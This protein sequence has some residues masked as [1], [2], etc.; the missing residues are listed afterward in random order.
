MLRLYRSIALLL[1]LLLLSGCEDVWAQRRS[2]N[3]SSGRSGSFNSSSVYKFSKYATHFDGVASASGE[4]VEC[5]DTAVLDGATKASFSFWIKQEVLWQARFIWAK[6]LTGQFQFAF[7][8]RTTN[9]FRV[10]FGTTTGASIATTITIP[11]G[12]FFENVWYHIVVAYDGTA[13]TNPARVKLFSN[14]VEVTGLS[15]SGTPPVNL[16]TGTTSTMRFGTAGAGPGGGHTPWRGLIDDAAVW[17]GRAFSQADIDEVYN[18]GRPRD[19]ST[20]SFGAP[21]LWYKMGDGDTQPTLIEQISGTDNCTLVN[22]DSSDFV[23][24]TPP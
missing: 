5:P 18:A 24:F 23:P 12:T 17:V 8:G 22:G 21:T 20:V 10:E 2:R 7:S 13:A 19:L 4:Y 11:N 6:Y 3:R 9:A 14:G 1:G 16:S 15:F